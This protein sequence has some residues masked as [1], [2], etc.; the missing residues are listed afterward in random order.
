MHHHSVV[1]FEIVASTNMAGLPGLLGVN[2]VLPGF[3]DQR[4]VARF[5]GGQRCVARFIGGHSWV[6]RFVGV[7]VSC[8]MIPPWGFVCYG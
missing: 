5:V 4:G 1:S 2:V 6:V 8:P 7:T 3:R